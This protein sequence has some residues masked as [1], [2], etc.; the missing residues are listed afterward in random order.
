MKRV[1]LRLA[2]LL[3]LLLIGVGFVPA[4]S[5]PLVA[6]VTLLLGWWPSMVRLIG[7]WHPSRNGIALFVFA[8]ILL[9]AGS[10][11]FLRWLYASLR[12]Q[13]D[14]RWPAYWRWKWTVCG[15]AML[16]CGLLAICCLVLTTHQIYWISKSSDPLFADPFRKGLTVAMELQTKADELRWNSLKTHEAFL[17]NDLYGG[18][19]RSEDIAAETIQPVW[20]E[21][22]SQTLRAIVLIPRR[23][24]F[25]T[26][27][28]VAVV[29]PGTNYFVKLDELPQ[30]LASFGIG[31]TA[32]VFSQ[33]TASRP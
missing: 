10:H 9:V 14:S 30:V 28:W 29:Q 26:T 16:A 4:I 27:A 15:F 2:V 8:V 33:G 22:D 32:Q 19:A 23:P 3:I 25:R 31:S 17:R 5:A 6:A 21:K 12:N 7:A 13:S 24:L 20:I 18:S 11:S 1:L